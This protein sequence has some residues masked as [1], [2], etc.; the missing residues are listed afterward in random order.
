MIRA[1]FR[2]GICCAVFGLF[3]AFALAQTRSDVLAQTRPDAGTLQQQIE[4]ERQQ[5][6]LPRGVAPEKPAVPPAMKPGAVALTVRQ[7]RFAGNT[8]LSSEKLAPVVAG[9]LNRP[10]DFAQLQ[11]AAVA[12]AE[13]Y[14]QAGWVVR[15]YLPAQTIAEGIITIQIVEAV[16]G[17]ARLEG[18]ESARVGTAQVLDLIAAQQKTGEPVYIDGLDR[19]LLLADDLPGVKVTGVLAEGA[20]PGETELLVKLA[21]EPLVTGEVSADNT[22]S[23][24]TGRERLSA[25]LSLN[26]PLGHGDL[27]SATLA[28]TQG[29]DYLRL[30]GSLPVGSDGWRVGASASHLQYQL[31][32]PEFAALDARGTA[33]TVGLEAS[34]PLLRS[35]LANLN[36][37]SSLDHK[38][39][40]NE[41]S[42]ATTSRYQSH[43]HTLGLSGNLYDSWGGGGANSASLA[44]VNGRLD[45]GG[46]PNQA[47]D[48]ATTR[49]HGSFMKWR[50]SLSRQQVL[51][52]ELSLF[53]AASAQRANKN[54][55]SSEKLFLGGASGIRAYPSSEAGG[56]EGE[57]LNLE[58]RWRPVGGVTLTA[59]HD[60]GRVRVNKDN[61][62]AAAAPNGITLKGHGLAAA[63]Q[64]PWDVQMKA[65]WA[66]REG[67]NPNPTAAG[68]DQDGSLIRDRFWVTTSLVF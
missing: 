13:A 1:F 61:S 63:W 8:L 68:L 41:S 20:R 29:S 6:M 56:A 4:R 58:L 40:D 37:S 32:A 59:F 53:A 14:R 51:T 3:P 64:T 22:G 28:H 48:A 42:G 5:Q 49:T 55:D 19:G 66:R 45:L 21:D 62:L 12:V 57:L 15:A 47:S 65:T 46:S 11:A 39:F 35:R 67:S 36:V 27:A 26:S 16:F 50:T 9:Y 33:E 17:G 31:I 54:L 52:E 18:P 60:W 24:S 2:V 44:L 34:Y 25:T 43:A 30:A 38:H 23:R 7:F 10:L